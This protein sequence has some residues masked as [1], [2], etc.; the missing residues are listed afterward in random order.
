MKVDVLTHKLLFNSS[1]VRKSFLFAVV[2][3]FFAST[4]RRTFF[5]AQS[6]NIVLNLCSIII[7][8]LDKKLFRKWL[9]GAFIGPPLCRATGKGWAVQRSVRWLYW[10][11][12]QWWVVDNFSLR[13]LQSETCRS[14][15]HVHSHLLFELIGTYDMIPISPLNVSKQLP[16][17]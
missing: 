9:L 2:E 12:L 17:H 14:W 7:C 16:L 15:L 1:C 4:L 8:H 6:A 13:Q 5:S 10:L 3:Y 11:A